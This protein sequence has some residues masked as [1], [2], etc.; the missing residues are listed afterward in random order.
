M[1]SAGKARSW[2]LSGVHVGLKEMQSPDKPGNV[3][4]GSICSSLPL[5]PPACVSSVTVAGRLQYEGHIQLPAAFPSQLQCW[6]QDSGAIESVERQDRGLLA[7]VTAG[8]QCMEHLP[9]S[10]KFPGRT[11]IIMSGTLFLALYS[12][13]WKCWWNCRRVM[14]LRLCTKSLG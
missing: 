11:G 12:G 8:W 13:T 6:A 4:A 10:G 14:Y 3:L 2:A 5:L 1:L 7:V 9:R